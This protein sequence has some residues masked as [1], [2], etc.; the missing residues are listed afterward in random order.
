[1]ALFGEVYQLSDIKLINLS[2]TV[3]K[4]LLDDVYNF[5]VV[6]GSGLGMILHPYPN[7]SASLK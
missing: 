5:S 2:L 1:M 4:G 6:L 3:M 7:P